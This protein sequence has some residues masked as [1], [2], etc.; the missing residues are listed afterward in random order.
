MTTTEG[1]ARGRAAEAFRSLDEGGELVR[2]R[3]W[4]RVREGIEQQRMRRRR[5]MRWYAGIAATAAACVAIV[6]PSAIGTARTWYEPS[7]AD[8]Q[9]VAVAAV[10]QMFAPQQDLAAQ[11]D[12]QGGSTDEFFGYLVQEGEPGAE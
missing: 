2:R 12:N 7:Q 11:G 4:S 6:L 8:E 1:S 10:M 9:R 3:V 5:R